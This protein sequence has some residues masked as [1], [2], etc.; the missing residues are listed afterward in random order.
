MAGPLRG[1]WQVGRG[2]NGREEGKA[3]VWGLGH[4]GYSS[5]GAVA[6]DNLVII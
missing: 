4:P 1:D 6:W 3:P 2:G 5:E